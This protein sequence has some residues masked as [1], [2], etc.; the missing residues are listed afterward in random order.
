[1]VCRTPSLTPGEVTREEVYVGKDS[2]YTKNF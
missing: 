1:M 2:K